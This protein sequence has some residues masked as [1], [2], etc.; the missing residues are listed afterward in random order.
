MISEHTPLE[1]LILSFLKHLSAI[2]SVIVFS[3]S[4]LEALVA[5][6]SSKDHV[7]S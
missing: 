6:T 7:K 4:A 1:S 5:L 2:Q 3:V